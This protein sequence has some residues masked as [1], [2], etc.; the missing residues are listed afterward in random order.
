MLRQSSV[1]SAWAEQPSFLLTPFFLSPRK[2]PEMQYEDLVKTIK[3][4][5]AQEVTILDLSDYR[6]TTLPPEIGLLVNLNILYLNNNFLSTLPPEIGKLKK[7]SRLYLNN[8]Q[9][10]S[11]PLEISQLT[12]LTHLYLRDNQLDSLPP[13]IGALTNLTHLYL[14]NNRLTALPR[15]IGQLTR[16]KRLYI[17]DNALNSLPVELEHLD[18]LSQLDI[19]MNPVLSEPSLLGATEEIE[20]PDLLIQRYLTE[21]AD[22]LNQAKLMVVGREGAG[23]TAVLRRLITDGFNEEEPT[24]PGIV[25][26]GWSMEVEGQT[27]RLNVWDFGGSQTTYAAHQFFLT[28]RAL[29]LLVIDTQLTESENHLEEWLKMIQAFGGKSPIIIV[30]NKIDRRPLRLDRRALSTKYPNIKG[31]VEISCLANF[32]IE[33]LRSL[34]GRE[35]ATLPHISDQLLL[36]WMSV[37][38]ELENLE[39]NLLEYGDYQELCIAKGIR[40]E[41]DQRQLV[42]LCHDLGEVLYYYKDPRLDS[43]DI[44]NPYTMI[45]GIYAIFNDSAL[46]T[47]HRGILKLEYLNRIFDAQDPKDHLFVIDMMRRFELGFFLD[48][49]RFLIPSLLPAKQPTINAWKSCLAYRY[50]Y[51]VLPNSII[52]R[53][54]V[55]IRQYVF[56]RAMWRTGV[57]LSHQGNKAIIKADLD[58]R[59]VWVW[60]SGATATAGELFSLISST[61]ESVHK[62]IPGLQVKGQPEDKLGNEE[63]AAIFQGQGDT[64]LQALD[65]NTT[66]PAEESLSSPPLP[67]PP[68]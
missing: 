60:V 12:N 63:F 26:Y 50:C 66:P 21:Q 25:T 32:G 7:L 53:T 59:E 39:E 64:S 22:R 4:T 46:I 51:D 35:L 37:K 34:V 68:D 31:F 40:K 19:R 47:E 9:L 56:R 6:L 42:T 8:N 18:Q 28:R 29:Y 36:S 16:L 38:R 52:S 45:Y 20:R 1:V 30:G 17:S 11:L 61:L 2:S 48:A 41:S 49:Q 65:L 33:I 3:Q 13:E 5:A 27:L 24:T 54:I 55:R 23:K 43:T 67:H 57:V 44:I 10:T 62:T 58:K 14:R 15:E